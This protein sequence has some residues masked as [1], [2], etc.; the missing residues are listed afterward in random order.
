MNPLRAYLF[1]RG[2]RDW[3]VSVHRDLQSLQEEWQRGR[4]GAVLT[5]IHVGFWR[6]DAA[7]FETFVQECR[8]LVLLTASAAYAFPP[9]VAASTRPLGL[10]EG[11]PVHVALAG[12]GYEITAEDLG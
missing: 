8:D 3:T 10:V 7:G 4:G 11:L 12:W 2:V 5:A 6:P 9:P 1:I